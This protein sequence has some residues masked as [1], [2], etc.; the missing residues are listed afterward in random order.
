MDR[1]LALCTVAIA[2]VFSGCQSEPPVVSLASDAREEKVISTHPVFLTSVTRQSNYR[3][4]ILVDLRDTSEDFFFTAE[5]YLS[6]QSSRF[7]S[8]TW[9]LL[10]LNVGD[11]A[12]C[13]KRFVQLPFEIEEGDTILFNLLD[14]DRLGAEQEQ[15]LLDGCRACGFCI[16]VAGEVYCP[17][18]SQLTMPLSMVASEILGEAITSEVRTHG[19]ENF[20]TAEYIVPASLPTEPHAANQLDIISR[21][22]Y[23][24]ASLKI[25]G[26]NNAIE[27]EYDGT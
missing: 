5:L 13:Q 10:P 17:G 6:V 15:L 22:N 16:V 3:P 4:A 12:G 18:S 2:L 20:G 14:N 11:F 19:F 21:S 27:F 8:N 24:P 26:P 7:P 1:S 23:A 9:I 25:F